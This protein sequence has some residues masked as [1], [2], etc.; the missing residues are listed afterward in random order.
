MTSRKGEWM[1]MVTQYTVRRRPS[2]WRWIWGAILAALIVF[3]VAWWVSAKPRSAQPYLAGSRPLVLG[4]Q[5][6]SAY[7]PSNTIPSFRKALEMGA[8]ILEMDIHLTKDGVIVVSHD[9]TVDRM[10]DGTGRIRDLTL[11]E[12]QRLDAGYRFSPDAGKTF[13]YRGQ[14]ISIP[15]L[16]EVF[17]TFPDARMNLEIKE[18]DQPIEVP[19]ANLV[20]A[21]GMTQKVLVTSFY[22]D[23]LGRF[24][25]LA[26]GVATAAA[27]QEILGFV[28]Q[29]KAGLS[30]LYHAHSDALQIPDDV[31]ESSGI[32]LARPSLIQ[33]AHRWN[34]KVQYWTVN[35][36]AEM[37]RLIQMG[38]DGI[39]TDRPDVAVAVL[40]ELGMR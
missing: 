3:G 17:R 20:H 33:A 39:I 34:Q 25:R 11:A 35:D 14:G 18:G 10:T 7:A 23:A 16:E 12:L 19:L 2:V 5:G 1:P 30:F 15:T 6:A 9:D 29:W 26:P 40:R 31:K 28:I 27:K 21:M 24:R 4:H 22:D 36:P 37:K 38:A 32:D 8:D 13:P